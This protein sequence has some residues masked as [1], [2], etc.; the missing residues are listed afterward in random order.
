MSEERRVTLHVGGAA[1]P[2][3]VARRPDGSATYKMPEAVE[4]TLSQEQR[5]AIHRYLEEQNTEDRRPPP[6]PKLRPDAPSEAVRRAWEAD[7]RAVQTPNA[8]SFSSL[9]D[10]I[11]RLLPYHLTAY[12]EFTIEV[13]DGLAPA[14]SAYDARVRLLRGRY[15]K[16][17]A[18]SERATAT[19]ATDCMIARMELEELRTEVF[20]ARQVVEHLRP[21][22]FHAQGLHLGHLGDD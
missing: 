9:E 4:R 3:T 17:T 5:A 6:A 11:D 19:S 13:R 15:K 18:D 8:S 7:R 10:A 1:L 2:I 16:L 22:P 20:A 14:P 21:R 12:P